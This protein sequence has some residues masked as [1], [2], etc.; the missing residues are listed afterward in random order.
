MK[1]PLF[2]RGMKVWCTA[3]LNFYFRQWQIHNA[4]V[5]SKI[6][7]PI[8]FVPTHQ[9][10]F[11]DAVLVICSQPRN[12]WSIAR[13][14]VFK[15]GL[16]TKLLTAV[17]IKPVFRMRDGFS[18]LKNNEAILQEWI[19][20]LAAGED[21]IIFAEGNHNE[22]YTRGELQKGFARM[23]L[24]FQHQ[25]ENIPLTIIPVGVHYDD[26]HSFRT[27]VLVNF[28]EP[29]DVNRVDHADL[30]ER[31]KLER[32]VDVTEQSLFSLTVNID[33]EQYA[34][35]LNFLK[36]HRVYEPDLLEQLERDREVL[37]AFP[38]VPAVTRLQRAPLWLR[39]LNPLVWLG[40]I[41]NLPPYAV[42]RNFIKSKVKD[43]QWFGSLKYAFGIFLV[44]L[45][46]LL[47]LIACYLI[48]GSLPATLIAALILPVSAMVAADALRR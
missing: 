27:R 16:V 36:K 10:A 2:F 18:T 9:N 43:P 46:Y 37:S 4:E 47:L 24:K 42:I 45:Y 6:K 13:A 39:L 21:I 41:L 35:K 33:G 7:G 40:W 28:G 44:P 3:G 29:I 48:T 14:S 8:I 34:E 17:R 25:H 31:E 26:H 12:P 38:E 19:S 5:I 11:L 30:N 32:I 22:P 23:A 20:M 1:T 15:K